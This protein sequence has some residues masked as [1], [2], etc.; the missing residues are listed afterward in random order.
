MSKKPQSTA[1]KGSSPTKPHRTTLS[2]RPSAQSKESKAS[3]SP[4][5]RALLGGLMQGQGERQ[6]DPEMQAAARKL[7]SD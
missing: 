1:R 4:A 2:D 6:K 7:L 5:A 3:S